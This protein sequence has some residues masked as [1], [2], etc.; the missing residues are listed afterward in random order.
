MKPSNTPFVIRM[1]IG[2]SF[3]FVSF[4]AQGVFATSTLT[5]RVY[6]RQRNPLP[7]IEVELLDDLYR[8]VTPG[9][10]T[11][12]DGS[13]R[14]Q[15][16]GLK[17]GNFTIK[18]YA[19]RYDF[20]D[21]AVSYEINTQNIRG[22]EGS[23]YF[24][25]DFYLSA[26]KGGIRDTE[27]G[28][29]FA[30][31]IPAEAKAAYERA[32]EDLV[33]QRQ[34][35]GLASLRKA[36]VLFP[37]YFL[38]LHRYGIELFNLKQYSESYQVFMKAVAVN[39]R[40]ATSFYYLGY[41]FYYLGKD[42]HKAART[43]LNEAHTL[44]PASIQVLWLLGKVER[45]L[46]NFADAEKHLLTAKK[47]SPSRIPE[48]H[49]EL[50]QLYANDLKKFEEAAIELEHYLKASKLSDVDEK[51]TRQIIADLR[52]KAKTQVDK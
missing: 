45:S 13:G 12:T 3:L 23:G 50:A 16:S 22:G 11:R 38:A 28:V 34:D 6:D 15:F 8:T 43:A 24:T 10:R 21:Q 30:Q 18:V 27:T 19:F 52:A 4:L 9:G 37:D 42:Y 32:L 14:Y 31:D 49:K 25:Q 47:L 41:A 29:V 48:I 39:P 51:K 7:D 44:A 35:E 5:G 1:V 36:L 17:N 40:S 33:K 46:G 26:K 2:V 20:E